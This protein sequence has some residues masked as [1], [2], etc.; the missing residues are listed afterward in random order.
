MILGW[1]L[2]FDPGIRSYSRQSL[3]LENIVVIEKE[4]SWGNLLPL[5]N[6]WL[7]LMKC[8]IG[9]GRALRSLMTFK[10]SRV[11][12]SQDNGILRILMRLLIR[13]LIMLLLQASLMYRVIMTWVVPL[14]LMNE[15]SL[16]M[17]SVRMIRWLLIYVSYLLTLFM[18]E[19][20]LDQLLRLFK[21]LL[22]ENQ[23]IRQ[24]A[25]LF[26]D[27]IPVNDTLFVTRREIG[28]GTFRLI[29]ILMRSLRS[30][31]ISMQLI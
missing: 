29:E 10:L 6:R 1:N 28:C 19:I 18:L 4:I 2:P 20:S 15:C 31:K 25:K 24:S 23:W 8:C 14:M 11:R 7:G 3:R 26:I 16:N 30:Q 5:T 17:R 13:V 21:L 12:L 22:S 9:L 27:L